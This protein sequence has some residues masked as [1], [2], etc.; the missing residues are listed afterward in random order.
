M[1]FNSSAFIF[2]FLPV[3]L[4]GFFLLARVA[5]M[6]AAAWLTAASLFFYG[7]WN[8]IYVGLLAVSIVC[9]FSFGTAIGRAVTAGAQAR[10]KSLLIGAVSTNLLVLA[11]FKY[12]NFFLGSFNHL[13]G[14]GLSLGEIITACSSPIFRI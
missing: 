6:L 11:Y 10:A 5:P 2:L 4:A 12:A 1:L 8:P 9:N 13:A 7:W 14:A 3:T